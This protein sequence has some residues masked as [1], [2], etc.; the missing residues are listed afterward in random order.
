MIIKD[1]GVCCEKC[2]K[3]NVCK[4][5]EHTSAL[6][7]AFDMFLKKNTEYFDFLSNAEVIVRCKYFQPDILQRGS[8]KTPEEIFKTVL[9]DPKRED[10]VI[11]EV[12]EDE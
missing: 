4:F 7:E 5:K 2:L 1:K 11:K 6:P 8:M 3:E 9:L 10:F 12:S